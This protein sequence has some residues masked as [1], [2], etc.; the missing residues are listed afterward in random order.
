MDPNVHDG[1]KGM[2]RRGKDHAHNRNRAGGKNF[3]L[4]IV[5]CSGGARM[6]ESALSLMQ[7]AKNRS[8][9]SRFLLADAG[10]FFLS[11]S[12][13]TPPPAGRNR[14]ASRCWG[15]SSSPNQKASD[16]FCRKGWT[17]WNTTGGG[18]AAG[19]SALSSS[20]VKRGSSTCGAPQGF[21]QSEIA[22][23]VDFA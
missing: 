2:R 19:I 8:G 23:L 12:W 18:I 16:W 6:Q 5:S 10:G 21:L 17:I 11:A 13:P 9:P 1:L 14:R 3:P 4:L 15:I 22:R 20:S 7:M